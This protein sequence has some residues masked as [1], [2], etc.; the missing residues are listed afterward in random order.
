MNKEAV[1]VY[2][3]PDH[4]YPAEVLEWLKTAPKWG[5]PECKKA[6]DEAR[7]EEWRKGLRA[8]TTEE[9]LAALDRERAGYDGLGELWG[10]TPIRTQ[11]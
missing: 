1:G 9:M 11:A 5:T 7:E 6:L 4:L 2:E 10:C 8:F 3:R